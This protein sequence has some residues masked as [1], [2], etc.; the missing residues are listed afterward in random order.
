MW[1]VAAPKHH[2]QNMGILA[3][4]IILCELVVIVTAWVSPWVWLICVTL[5][6]TLERWGLHGTGR[7]IRPASRSFHEWRA[8]CDN[9]LHTYGCDFNFFLN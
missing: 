3:D 1:S 2:L 4:V 7:N 9:D 5:R 8:R 6:N